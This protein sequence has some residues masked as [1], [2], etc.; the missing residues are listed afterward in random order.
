MA[1]ARAAVRSEAE[2]P[3]S[4][5]SIRGMLGIRKFTKFMPI[6][7]NMMAVSTS[8]TLKKALKRPGNRPQMAPPREAARRHTYQGICSSMAQV[9]ARKAPMVYWPEAPMLKR[10][11]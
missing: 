3:Q 5:S 9:R 11:T 10:P 2:A 4:E 6:Q 1:L 7:L 8:F